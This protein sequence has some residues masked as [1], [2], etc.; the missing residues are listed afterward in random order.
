MLDTSVVVAGL[1]SRRGASNALLQATEGGHATL[2]V[3]PALFLEYEAVLK[4]AEQRLAHGLSLAQVDDFLDDLAV[5][6]ELVLPDF[7]WRPL[8]SDADDEMVAEAALN[9]GADA[10]VT[11]NVRDFAPIRRLGVKVWSPAQALKGVRP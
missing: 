2:L 9:G 8:L 4:R 11:H 1:R 6:C 7:T 10:I 5:W 3:T